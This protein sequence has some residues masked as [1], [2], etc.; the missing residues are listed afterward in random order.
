MMLL[1]G[2]T[3]I[4]LAL[5][6]G[7][8]FKAGGVRRFDLRGKCGWRL[9]IRTFSAG[10]IYAEWLFEALM[11]GVW[12]MD[13]SCREPGL[14]Y[15]A[16]PEKAVYTYEDYCRLPEGAP[17]ELIGGKLV[18]TP[19]PGKKH[20]II[21]KRLLKL[22]DNYVEDKDAGE[23]LCVP[24]DVCLA[25]TE[26]YQPDILFVAKDRLEISAEDKVN[27]APDMIAEIL[28]PSNA[29]YDLRKKF[30]AYEKYG[31]R[32]YWI[33]DPEEAS[34]EVYELA[35]GKF[36][37]AAQKE[38]SGIVSSVVLPGFT[39]KLEDIFPS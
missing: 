30:K 24:R 28:S 16:I 22:L 12:D 29:Y 23:V 15:K 7:L 8:I 39:I 33:V 20:Q 27:G 9:L 3:G 2:H 35:D 5:V 6:R 14:A 17:Y 32:E 4:T 18:M 21:L 11:E 10:T 25:P 1:L 36:R 34:I 37:L 38:K 13:A 19:S 26:V 31:V